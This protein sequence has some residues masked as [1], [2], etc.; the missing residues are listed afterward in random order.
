MQFFQKWFKHSKNETQNEAL[1]ASSK[2]EALEDWKKVP[3]YIPADKDDYQTVS[4]I[5]S[6]I[7]AS[8]RPNSQFKMKRIL[9]RNPEAVTVSLIASSIAAGVYSESQFRVTSIYCKR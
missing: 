5:A 8:D 6:A 4:L 1:S 9:K 2:T 7:A 3:A